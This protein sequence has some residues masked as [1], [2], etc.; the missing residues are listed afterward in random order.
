MNAK[1]FMLAL[2]DV[3]DTFLSEAADEDNI[4]ELFADFKAEADEETAENADYN[5]GGGII[6][7]KEG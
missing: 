1:D 7:P 6:P 4:K 3:E 2:T 5:S